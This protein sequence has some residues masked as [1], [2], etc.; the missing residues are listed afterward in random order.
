MTAAPDASAIRPTVAVWYRGTPAGVPVADELARIRATGFTA[1][2]WPG[3][4]ADRTRAL[5]R[6]AGELSLAVVTPG[7][8]SLEPTRWL[9]VKVAEAAL[10]VLPAQV[11][12]AIGRGARLVSFD[13]GTAIGSGLEDAEGGRAPWVAP[14]LAIA[15][16]IDA[17]AE[18]IGQLRP[19]GV[20]AREASGRLMLLDAGRAWVLIAANP[21]REAAP[22]T[23]A[24]PKSIPYGPWINLV[25]GSDMAMVSLPSHH[26]YRATLPSGNARV[27]VVDKVR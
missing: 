27:Y 5:A 11:W 9:D 12:L 26:E 15:R 10:E 1:V 20:E 25:D 19:A 23:A 8:A 14:A 7:E 22:L 24:F 16:V 6:L 4:D 2:M 3:R 18:L 13:A 21:G 17:N